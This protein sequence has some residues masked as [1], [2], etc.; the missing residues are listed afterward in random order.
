MPSELIPGPSVQEF[1][2]FSIP[3]FLNSLIQQHKLSFAGQNRAASRFLLPAPS[4]FCRFYCRFYC[5][6]W[7]PFF[8]ANSPDDMILRD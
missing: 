4:S 7:L 1:L 2:N 3:Q 6:F 8:K 5:R